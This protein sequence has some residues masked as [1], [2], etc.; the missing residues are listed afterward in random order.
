M[1]DSTFHLLYI[2][3]AE[4]NHLNMKRPRQLP[5]SVNLLLLPALLVK[6]EIRSN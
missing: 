4:T 1:M 3:L 6:L 5:A 2:R